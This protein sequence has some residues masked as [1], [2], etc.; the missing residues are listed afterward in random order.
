MDAQSCHIDG[1]GPYPVVCPGTVS[2]L[3]DVVREARAVKQAVYTIGG[4]TLLHIGSPP[5]RAGVVADLRRLDHVIDYPARDMTITVQAGITLERLQALLRRENQ[6]LPVDVPQADRATLGGAIAVNVSGP[7]R[8]GFGTLRDYVI[9]ISMVNDEGQPFKAGGRVV[10]NVAGYDICK[11]AIGS[12]GTLGI[13]TQVTLKLRPLPEEQA[14]AVLPC[15]GDPE[16]ILDCLHNSRTRPVC[17]DLLSRAAIARINR[18]MSQPLAEQDW[19][20]VVGFEDNREA[21]GWQ[22]QELLRELPEGGSGAE[23]RLSTSAEPLWLSLSEFPA[24]HGANMVLKANVLPSYVMAFCQDVAESIPGAAIQ[25]QAGNGIVLVR[26][27][28]SLG[29]EEAAVRLTA[30]REKAVTARGNLVVLRCPYEWKKTLPVWGAPRGD[31]A[32]M[33]SIK[34]QVDPQR[35][36]NPGR[37]VDGL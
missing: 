33:R 30:L 13:I 18:Y 27:D 16:P 24:E 22:I 9:G 7:R 4:R 5:A 3:G 32:M 1:F 6:R 31:L 14:L 35:I 12:L 25:A 20:I 10:K 23:V 34:D 8:Y 28:E 37:F 15:R 17:M 36:F 29:L 21:V 19:S 11:L 26:C 2:E